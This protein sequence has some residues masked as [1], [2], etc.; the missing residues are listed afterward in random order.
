[1]SG[2]I[3]I[4]PGLLPADGSQMTNAKLR[5]IASP[6]GQVGPGQITATEL[7]TTVNAALSAATSSITT[8]TA[9]A[10]NWNVVAA[11]KGTLFDVSPGASD[12]TATLPSAVTAGNGWFI[13]LRK[14][15]TGVGRVLTSPVTTPNPLVLSKQDQKSLIYTDGTNYYA[16]PF[17][18]GIDATGNLVLSNV[19]NITL[20]PTNMVQIGGSTALFPGIKASGTTAAFRL[21]DDSSDAS[22]TGKNLTATGRILN[23]GDVAIT[24][25]SNAG[26]VDW[27]LGNSFY[28]PSAIT[29]ATTITISNNVNGQT[30]SFAILQDGTGSRAITWTSTPA[31][32][33]PGQST[34]GSSGAN[35]WDFYT[36]NQKNGVLFGIQS[37]NF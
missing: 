16:I 6:T 26:T 5:Q 34:P 29:A 24:I 25:T 21:A 1:M 17:L 27:S 9:K 22:I 31:I 23:I 13:W 12:V 8:V 20:V 30:I 19:L 28:T 11:D 15:D 10:A 2:S 3:I 32:K 14:A 33:W 7:S 4:T 35:K 18:V 36:L 37:A